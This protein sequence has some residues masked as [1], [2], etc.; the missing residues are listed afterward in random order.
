M[1]E[2]SERS[3]KLA[4]R[5]AQTFLLRICTGEDGNVYGTLHTGYDDRAVRFTGMDQ[6]VLMINECLDREEQP[7]AETGLRTFLTRDRSA[8][9]MATASVR[10]ETF[11]RSE[12]Y[13]S[14]LISVIRRRN[15]SWQGE[16]R[17]NG[18]QVYF[19]SVLELLSLIRSVLDRDDR[20]EP[21]HL[22][23]T[24]AEDGETL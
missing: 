2:A 24:G 11:S 16:V 14:F 17:W 19:R 20:K 4:H 18:K 22:L 1:S 12:P 15:T 3:E 23:G 10:D 7:A 6:A 21:A 13:E 5:A 9:E 8:W